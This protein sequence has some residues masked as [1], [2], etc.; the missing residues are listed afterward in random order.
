MEGEEEGWR[1]EGRS[2]IVR[3]ILTSL[4]SENETSGLCCDQHPVNLVVM[5]QVGNTSSQ[6][7]KEASRFTAYPRLL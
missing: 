5:A 6:S 3:K 1:E 2:E 4:V 7:S